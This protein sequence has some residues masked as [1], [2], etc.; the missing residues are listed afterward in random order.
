MNLHANIQNGHG[1]QK[2]NNQ[3]LNSHNSSIILFGMCKF[4]E[5][6]DIYHWFVVKQTK[7]EK[8]GLIATTDKQWGTT[9]KCY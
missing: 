7:F 9:A 8:K 3:Q 6:K 5:K 1:L 2:K 4:E